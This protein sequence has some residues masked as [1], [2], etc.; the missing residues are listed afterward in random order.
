[1]EVSTISQTISIQYH[2]PKLTVC[3]T[4][5]NNSHWGPQYLSFALLPF[6]QLLAAKTFRV[7]E[8]MVACWRKYFEEGWLD[9]ASEFAQAMYYQMKSDGLSEDDLAR[10]QVGHSHAI[11]ATTGPSSW[12]LLYHIFSNPT[13]LKDVVSTCTSLPRFRE[14]VLPCM[15]S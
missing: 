13:I 2:C 3:F 6:K 4:F 8:F 9:Q 12:W 1:M 15:S 11:V 14:N 5:V 7:R 10:A